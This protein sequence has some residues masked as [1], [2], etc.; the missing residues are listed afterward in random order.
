VPVMFV[1]LRTKLSETLD[2]TGAPRPVVNSK[3]RRRR[4][5]T[6]TLQQVLRCDD[7]QFID[8][9]AKCLVWDPERRLKPQNALKHPFVLASKQQLRSKV[10]STPGGS[11]S[12]KS[13]A[14]LSAS[15]SRSKPL[16]TPK[17]SQISAPAPL[18]ARS[19]RTASAN[20]TTPSNSTSAHSISTSRSYRASQVQSGYHS[21]RTL[22]GFTVR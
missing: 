18:T 11:S 8:F 3:G 7:E 6:K 10:P 4:P 5:G 14:S 17:K 15:A 21:S 13:L 2:S 20:P 1:F 19:S 16:E 22:N 12:S 9:I